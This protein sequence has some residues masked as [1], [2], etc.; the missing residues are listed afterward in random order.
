MFTPELLAQ[1]GFRNGLLA[2]VLVAV[3]IINL[4]PGLNFPFRLINTTFHE[5]FHA[6]AAAFSG[7]RVKGFEV[8]FKPKDDAAG[9]TETEGGDTFFLF[10]AGYLGTALLSAGL[11]LVAGLP[12]IAP[13]ALGI[14]GALLILFTLAFAYWR[15][16]AA[17]LIGLGFGALFIWVAWRTDLF[18]AIL[19]LNLIAIQGGLM[20]LRSLQVLIRSIPGAK[21]SDDASQMASLVGC[22]PM[23][24]AWLWFL[25]SA[26][27]LA[28]A[29]WF[30]WLRNLTA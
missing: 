22:S 30:T 9:I 3:I 23:L 14:L 12:T 8:Y 19:L 28:S 18:W 17:L 25:L 24:M 20:A 13:N 2:V 26:G 4:V 29:F 15:S 27:A 6:I 7:G 21:G 16:A 10:P 1:P 5:L 11:M